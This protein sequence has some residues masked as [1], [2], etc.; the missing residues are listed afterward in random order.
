[1]LE[2]YMDTI[3]RLLAKHYFVFLTKVI[4]LISRSVKLTVYKS[5]F[6]K[7]YTGCAK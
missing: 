5:D 6:G 4:P 2:Y 1:M 3:R 7:N